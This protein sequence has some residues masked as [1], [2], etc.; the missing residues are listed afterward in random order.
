MKKRFLIISLVIG[1]FLV[2]SSGAAMAL[3]P[4]DDKVP[5]WNGNGS[6]SFPN[7][8][9]Y[10]ED[11]TNGYFYPTLYLYQSKPNAPYWVDDTTGLPDGND[12]IPLVVEG[13]KDGE[14]D[15]DTD[16]NTTSLNSILVIRN[17]GGEYKGEYQNHLIV[18]SQ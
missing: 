13:K 3:D 10:T 15:P 6:E 17:W 4:H 14:N 5:L 2:L 12:A 7:V 16:S 18:S 9:E 8:S 11:P 1:L